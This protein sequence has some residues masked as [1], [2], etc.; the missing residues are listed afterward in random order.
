MQKPERWPAEN[1]RGYSTIFDLRIHSVGILVKNLGAVGTVL[2]NSECMKC[3]REKPSRE[4][5]PE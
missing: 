5:L 2:I 1:L 4:Q 3:E